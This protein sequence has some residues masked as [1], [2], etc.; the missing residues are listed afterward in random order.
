MKFLIGLLISCTIFAGFAI[1]QTAAVVKPKVMIKVDEFTGKK[2]VRLEKVKLTPTLELDLESVKSMK[3]LSPMES[4]LQY[5]TLTFTNTNS[6]RLRVRDIEVNFSVDSK[7]VKG[8]PGNVLINPKSEQIIA[9]TD[10]SNLALVGKGK[11]VKMKIGD[12]IF[13]LDSDTVKLI[14]DFVRGVQN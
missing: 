13:D 9:V 10:I 5:A 8:G 1:G 12:T 2:T 7:I 14:A 11:A 4:F 6:A 3:P